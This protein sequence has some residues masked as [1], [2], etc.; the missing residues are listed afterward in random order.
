MLAWVIFRRCRIFFSHFQLFLSFSHAG[1]GDSA[2]AEERGAFQCSLEPECPHCSVLQCKSS[3]AP[4][5]APRLTGRSA[6]GMALFSCC[7]FLSAINAHIHSHI[8]SELTL[9]LMQWQ[10]MQWVLVCTQVDIMLLKY[11]AYIHIGTMCCCKAYICY[12]LVSVLSQLTELC[13]HSMHT[14]HL[15]SF[16]GHVNCPIPSLAVVK[17]HSLLSSHALVLNE[18]PLVLLLAG[19]CTWLA[20]Q[21]CLS[22]QC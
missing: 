9:A 15:C 8:S 4:V 19:R 22:S 14:Q 2:G 20:G 1:K 5:A 17:L 21:L 18:M 12:A 16:D 10:A 11:L 7:C 13:S 6:T 3:T